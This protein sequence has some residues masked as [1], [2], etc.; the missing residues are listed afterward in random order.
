MLDIGHVLVVLAGIGPLGFQAWRSWR[1]ARD[2]W[3]DVDLDARAYRGP[4]AGPAVIRGQVDA[5]LASS[6]ELP[7]G[8]PR[9][10][11]LATD[12][13]GV[14]LTMRGTNAPT[15]RLVGPLV[16]RSGAA[17]RERK[18]GQ[19]RV[20]W[21]QSLRIAREDEC[22]CAGE[23]VE[24]PA[25]WLLVGT[26]DNPIRA[27]ATSVGGSPQPLLPVRA[28]V[29]GLALAV[30]IFLALHGIG[31]AAEDELRDAAHSRKPSKPQ[32]W[33]FLCAISLGCAPPD[34]PR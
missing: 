11:E 34:V 23:L 18:S 14:I 7:W 29:A 31:R 21:R 4:V 22:I 13:D 32:P 24:S 9:A 12:V 16:V 33:R 28:V 5:A 25:G 20:L 19:A 8:T 17:S 1:S 6:R 10:R 30:C 27:H 3:R 15:M 2:E 26:D